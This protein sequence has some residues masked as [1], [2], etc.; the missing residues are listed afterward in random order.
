M[1]VVANAFQTEISNA[2]ASRWH[3]S[4]QLNFATRKKKTILASNRHEGPLRVQRPFYP[5]QDDRCHC[6]LLHPPGGVVGGDTLDISIAAEQNTRV[7][8]TTPGAGKFYKSPFEP[9]VL[10]NRIVL[11]VDA[12]LEWL[13]QETIFFNGANAK[14]KTVFDLAD[15]ACL[16]AWDITCLGRPAANETFDSG[17]IAQSFE[18]WK[19]SKPLLLERFTLNGAWEGL[20]ASW[21]WRGYS[22]S[23]TFIAND[24]AEEF[25]P[26][27]FDINENLAD[28]H[29]AI[30]K[31]GTLLV[32]RYLGNSAE[33]A[34]QLLT[35]IWQHVRSVRD[36]TIP[37]VPR[38]W[39]T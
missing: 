33:Q 15:G 19:N 31:I 9:G 17:K 26:L 16:C 23:A 28:A 27:P 38:I 35:R 39:Y 34:K 6:Y 32:A 10:C 3:A 2:P 18:V 1:S 7:L 30:T 22:V 12:N 4:L 20:H 24:Y 5:E 25:Y 8:L 11:G 13:P 29:C 36:N 21:G 14:V 37:V